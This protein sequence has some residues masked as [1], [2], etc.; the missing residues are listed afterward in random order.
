MNRS[1]WH[2]HWQV[3]DNPIEGKL[4]ND[5]IKAMAKHD[6][7]FGSMWTLL[8]SQDMIEVVK[9]ITAMPDL[10]NDPYMHGAGLHYHPVPFPQLI[11]PRCCVI[12]TLATLFAMVHP[13]GAAGWR[14]TST[15]PSTPSAA[16]S[17]G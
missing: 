11:S 9:R 13:R 15:T 4:A 17:A 6:A 12:L 14:C 10:E 5:N 7:I 3:Y 8:Q 1:L 2:P 16:R